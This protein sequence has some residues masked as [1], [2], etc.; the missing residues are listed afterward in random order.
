M[1]SIFK[2]FEKMMVAASFAEEGE[3]ET[4]RQIMN[5]DRPRKTD[6]PS[7]YDYKRPAARKEIRAD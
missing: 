2:K 7:T 3:F 5:E 1:T 6:R 4:A